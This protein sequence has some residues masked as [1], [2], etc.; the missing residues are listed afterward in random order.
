MVTEIYV[1]VMMV[2]STNGIAINNIPGF[3][4]LESCERE[5]KKGEAIIKD[6]ARHYRYVCIKQEFKTDTEE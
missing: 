3:V 2:F 6:T 4:S 1:L 5:G